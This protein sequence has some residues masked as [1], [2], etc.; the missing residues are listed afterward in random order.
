MIKRH[1]P[2]Y[3]E[4]INLLE[5]GASSRTSEFHQFVFSSLND[6]R[7]QSRYVV[8]R[9]FIKDNHNLIFF[10]DKR[11]PKVNAI[12]K[13][14]RTECLFYDKI[15][16]IQ[17]RIKTNSYILHDIKKIT[18]YW[19]KVPLVSRQSYSTKLPPSTVIKG[20][21]IDPSNRLS[22]E[23]DNYE[24]SFCNFCVIENY[25]KEIDFLSLTSSPH[26]RISITIDDSKI[27]IQ[28]LIP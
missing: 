16:K 13:N 7:V 1:H 2:L 24:K 4:T 3:L 17:L 28:D 6:D 14:S 11:S 15:K 23:E 21:Q 25:I 8:L 10:T 22:L 27:I 18:E 5:N 9:N 20:E 12:L 19:E 26:K